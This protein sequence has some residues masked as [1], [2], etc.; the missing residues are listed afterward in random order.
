MSS[1]IRIGEEK[2]SAYGYRMKPLKYTDELHIEVKFEDGHTVIVPLF[3]FVKGTVRNPNYRVLYNRGYIGEFNNVFEDVNP[4]IHCYW[5]Q[6]FD[7]CYLIS[8]AIQDSRVIMENVSRDWYSYQNFAAWFKEN[9]YD[10]PGEEM[11]ISNKIV[12]DRCNEYSRDTTIFVPK[13]I[14]RLID[15]A[16]PKSSGHKTY[17]TENVIGYFASLPGSNTLS[18]PFRTEFSANMCLMMQVKDEIAKIADKY[19]QYL[20]CTVYS[21][22]MNYRATIR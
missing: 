12:S 20:P 4:S 9:Y 10:I 21:A 15:C 16:N 2:L 6:M 8:N 14:V 11:V 5:K 17:V 1:C 13:S 7:N 19:K 18:G 22:L 3:Q